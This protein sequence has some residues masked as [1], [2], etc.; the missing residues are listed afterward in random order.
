MN[1]E[2]LREYC[3]SLSPEVEEK[4]PFGKFKHARDVL[5]FYIGG[6]M[7]CYFDIDD[8][9]L[10]NVKCQPERID[11]MRASCSGIIKPM[12][13]SPKHWVGMVPGIVDDDIAHELILNS[14]NLVKAKYAKR[15]RPCF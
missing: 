15:K 3:L 10:V 1:I 8:F 6:H 5:V 2:E 14:Y 7:F 9:R 13:A 12:N 4:F 11:E